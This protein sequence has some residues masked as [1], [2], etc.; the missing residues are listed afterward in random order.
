VKNPNTS[1][2]IADYFCPAIGNTGL[3]NSTAHFFVY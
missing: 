3:I 2:Y 1:R